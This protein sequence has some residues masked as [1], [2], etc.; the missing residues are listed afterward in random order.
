MISFLA[1]VALQAA[2]P[3]QP[4]DSAHIGCAILKAGELAT[5][6]TKP[7]GAIAEEALA[8]CTADTSAGPA[9]DVTRLKMRSAAIAMVNR[10]RG[11]D[12]QAA[13]API[14]VPNMSDIGLGSIDIP[15]EI[16]PALLPYMNCRNVSAGIAV[17]SDGKR[18]AP[19]PGIVK[20]SD[21]SAH[22]AKAAKDANLM[23][24]RA[25]RRGK[26]E[27]AAFVEKALA[28]FDRFQAAAAAF[29]AQSNETTE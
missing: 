1:A 23:L 12:G 17:F 28:D 9:S 18:V 6:S 11:T 15:D 21:C 19:P 13:D 25:G 22:R 2:A 7:A 4:A 3:A 16:A 29:R 5:A 14:R 27:R 24:K 10:R 20:G 8:A 26:K